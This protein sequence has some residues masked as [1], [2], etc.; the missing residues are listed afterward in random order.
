MNLWMKKLPQLLLATLTAVSLVSIVTLTLTMTHSI[1]TKNLAAFD[2]TPYRVFQTR[3]R[4]IDKVCASTKVRGKVRGVYTHKYGVLYCSVPKAGCT[5][6]K[7]VF[8]TANRKDYVNKSDIFPLSKHYIHSV[9]GSGKSFSALSSTYST[10]L[11]VVRDPYSRLLSAYLD[12]FY[13][14]NFWH[15]EALR[16]IKMRDS[17]IFAH[18]I[19]AGRP[20]FLRR[21]YD[22]VYKLFPTEAAGGFSRNDTTC[23]KYLT[24]QDF[25]RYGFFVQEPHWMPIHVICN[26]CLLN[27]SHVILMETFTS[28]ARVLLDKMGM[29]HLLDDVNHETQINDDIKMLIEYNFDIISNSSKKSFYKTCITSREL[30]FRLWQTFRWK[31]YIDPDIEYLIPDFTEDKK[32]KKNLSEQVWGAR[33]SGLKKPKSMKNARE[34]FNIAAFST[35]SRSLFTILSQKYQL[36]I[37]LFGYESIRDKMFSSI[38]NV[39]YQENVLNI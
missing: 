13:L 23:G 30:G 31:G 20:D 12:K 37:R 5:F 3:K 32:V 19:G 28:D 38:Y 18:V 21:H 29:G 7:S 33:T 17:P 1:K 6:W 26:P 11:L 24:F 9:Y 39:N 8:Y 36:D 27:V 34:K 14:P 4:R 22:E 2:K 16:L 15:S 25:I 35:L 10:R